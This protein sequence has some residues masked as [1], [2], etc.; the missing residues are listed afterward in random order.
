VLEFFASLPGPEEI[1]N[2]R[3]SERLERRVRN[4]LERSR[5]ATLTPQE[6]E[7]WQSYQYLEHLVRI[8]KAKACLKMG[9]TPA[10]G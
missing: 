6:E 5:T 4:L 8:A 7:E 9:I 1:L 10:D 3:P 2:L